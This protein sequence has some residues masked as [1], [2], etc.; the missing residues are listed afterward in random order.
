MWNELK[1]YTEYLESEVFYKMCPI[2]FKTMKC[3]DNFMGYIWS[4][5]I[6]L[7]ALPLFLW[8]H[9]II[10]LQKL[11]DM[12]LVKNSPPSTEPKIS[13]PYPHEP[14]TGT[15]PQQLQGLM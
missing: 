10:P 3:N 8:T 12:Q 4:K 1:T 11:I 15:C 6:E 2:S 14:A 7:K 9:H 5:C 13:L